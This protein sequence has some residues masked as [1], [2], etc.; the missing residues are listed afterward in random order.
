M[1]VIDR[2]APLGPAGAR[3]RQPML[4]KRAQHKE[5]IAE[6]GD[7]MPEVRELEVVVISRLGGINL[8]N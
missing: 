4:D 7:D 5:H 3:V 8:R 1:D 2:V 6:H